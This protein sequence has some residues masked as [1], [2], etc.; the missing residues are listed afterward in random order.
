MLGTAAPRAF[1]AAVVG[2]KIRID[3][4]HSPAIEQF[5]RTLPACSWSRSDLCWKC[6][7]TPAAAWRLL[8]G[9]V[10]F[11][12]DDKLFALAAGIQEAQIVGSGS[13][14]MQPGVRKGDLWKHQLEAFRFAKGLPAVMLHLGMGCGKSATAIS[15]IANKGCKLVLIACPK[16]V[17]G[18]WTREFS[19]H[20]P[21]PHR[22]TLL[23]KGNAV[24]KKKLVEKELAIAKTFQGFQSTKI[25]VIV[26]NYETA[27]LSPLLGVLSDVEWD[28]VVCDESQRIKAHNSQQSKAMAKIGERAKFRMALTGTPMQN[29][30]MDVFGQFRFLDPGLFGT[31]YHGFRSRYA[32]TGHFGADHIVGFK[33]QEELAARMGLLTFHADRSVLDLPDVQHMTVPVTLSPETR[34]LYTALEQE[35]IAQIQNGTVTVANALTKTLRLRQ[36]TGGFTMLDD[37]GGMKRPLV[38]TGH[39]KQ[40]ALAE[41]LDA[42]GEPMVVFCEFVHDLDQI[43]EAVKAAGKRYGEV[44]GR[45]KDLTDHATMP[46]TVDVMGVQ[47][48]SGGVGVDLTRAPI[49]V[50]WNHPWSP[51]VYDQSEARIHRPGQT[52]PVVYYHL[53]AEGTVD[54]KVWEAL[55]AKQDVIDTVMAYM[56]GARS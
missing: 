17:M 20:C 7:A 18:V 12:G 11:S 48:R 44:S 14:L 34:K 28:A 40:E 52:K 51:G 35:M 56:K 8:Y 32:E 15:L 13:V 47:I 23:N 19:K 33:N 1:R 30:P 49:G 4:P 53:I 50:Y 43:A 37:D 16:S 9:E 10:R 26:V 45:R 25:S 38:V 46:D 27:K 36:I 41:L 39:E 3:A 42:S 2:P 54:Q 55:A 5:L 21:V 6:D 29:S 22:V 24:D 31:S